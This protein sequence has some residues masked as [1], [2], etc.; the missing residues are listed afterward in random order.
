[1]ASTDAGCRTIAC[2]EAGGS[3]LQAVLFRGTSV[4]VDVHPS[5]LEGADLLGLAVPGIIRQGR[6]VVA[7]NL[8]WRDVDPAAELGLPR[9][10][11]LVLN[12]G[13]AAALGEAALRGVRDLVYVGLGTGV[14][15]AVV[16]GGA[17]V[18]DNLFG[19]AGGFSTERCPCGSSGC[20]ETVAAGWALPA[21]LTDE[22]V[23][24]VGAATAM[25]IAREPSARADLPVVVGGGMAR[26]YPALVAAVAA[27][28]P[29]RAVESSAAPP[30]A[31]SAAAWGVHAA[32]S[33]L[34]VE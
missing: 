28:L 18:A 34:V 13:E 31:K 15:G 30:A 19:H 11:D 29:G 24:V 23:Q 20:L 22:D 10:A 6:V 7:S 14:G 2:V 21:T 27:G 5:R 4:V 17:I 25:A 3:G 1:M 16:V 8:G 32:L 33:S 9:R 12:D 26:R